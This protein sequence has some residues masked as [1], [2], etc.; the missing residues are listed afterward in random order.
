MRH[1]QHRKVTA[2]LEAAA[3]F[4]AEH[5]IEVRYSEDQERDDH[6]RFS[7]PGG[8]GGKPD[9]PMEHDAQA[10]RAMEAS[11]LANDTNDKEYHEKA[12]KEQ[13]SA[14]TLAKQ[15]GRPDEAKYH[16][17]LATDHETAAKGSTTTATERLRGKIAESKA[18]EG[19]AAGKSDLTPNKKAGKSASKD[20]DPGAAKNTPEHMVA[21]KFHNDRADELDAAGHVDAAAAHRDAA[22]SHGKAAVRGGG[23]AKAKADSNWAKKEEARVKGGAVEQQVAA[24]GPASD[25][26]KAEGKAVADRLEAGKSQGEKNFGKLSET[27]KAQFHKDYEA[28]SKK[29]VEATAKTGVGSSK[30]PKET[31]QAFHE[32]MY[33]QHDRRAEMAHLTN[34]PKGAEADATAALAHKE[35]G[36]AAAKIASGEKAG[37]TKDITRPEPDHDLPPNRTPDKT[38]ITRPQRNPDAAPKG[39]GSGPSKA[40]RAAQEAWEGGGARTAGWKEHFKNQAHSQSAQAVGGRAN[41]MGFAADKSKSPGSHTKA[42]NLHQQAAV[43][44]AEE[45][46]SKT[47]ADRRLF[48]AIAADHQTKV[49]YHTAKAKAMGKK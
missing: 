8:G 28:A 14:A 29:A 43:L 21:E 42:A 16:S 20:Y 18:G 27:Q 35:A 2:A 33:Q 10:A 11:K 40:E 34:D 1:R 22:L 39:G 15:A 30:D 19:G 24:G 45:A 4:A 47:G 17:R 46:K 37:A 7:G 48:L 5:G 38:D 36:A 6:G 44:N 26:T 32:R 9:Y 31:A 41:E 25:Q 23:E 49:A 3:K 13:V 12:A